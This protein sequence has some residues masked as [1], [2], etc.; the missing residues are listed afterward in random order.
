MPRKRTAAKDCRAPQQ[1]RL[2]AMKFWSRFQNPGPT[3]AFVGLEV[4]DIPRKSIE[5]LARLPEVPFNG[6]VI[7]SLKIALND[8]RP[9]IWRR[10]LVQDSNLER[11]HHVIQLCVGWDDAHLHGF[12]IRNIGIPLIEDGGTINE[13]TISLAQLHAA[14][15]TTLGYTYDFGDDWGHTITIE[16]TLVAEVG[17]TY[18][19]CIDG[20]GSCPEE[21]TGGMF[22]WSRLLRT[23]LSNEHK[24]DESLHD[25]LERVGEDYTPPPFDL[26]RTNDL[27]QQMFNPSIR[28]G[29]HA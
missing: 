4:D 7:Y 20:S 8:A 2:A 26:A 5:K 22:Q 14:R 16:K 10:V 19:Q 21:D 1:P 25:L 23:L 29:D 27:L 24:H 12:E 11:L 28:R 17:A 13:G 3:L 15:V 9:P 6:S 18:P